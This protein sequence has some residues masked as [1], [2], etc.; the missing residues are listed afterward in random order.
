MTTNFITWE[1]ACHKKANEVT[2]RVCLKALEVPEVFH[3]ML[4]SQI[5]SPGL[6]GCP[7]SLRKIGL[8]LLKNGREDEMKEVSMNEMGDFC[9]T[10][11]STL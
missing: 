4:S 1:I 6:H 9:S 2:K 7:F 8:F 11:Y 5:S 10:V 3:T